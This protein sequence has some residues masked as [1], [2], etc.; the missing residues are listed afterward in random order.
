MLVMTT[1]RILASGRQY[2]RLPM[3][4]HAEVQVCTSG[5]LALLAVLTLDK[6]SHTSLCPLLCGCS[7]GRKAKPA[8][9]DNGQSVNQRG[10]FCAPGKKHGVYD[11]RYERM[12]EGV[13]CTSGV[14]R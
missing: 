4:A 3:M 6:E 9:S 11:A 5:A 14:R 2:T 10:G 7:Q 8:G 13:A 1:P 12:W